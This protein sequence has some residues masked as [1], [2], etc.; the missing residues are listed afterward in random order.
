[1][2]LDFVFDTETVVASEKGSVRVFFF[3]PTSSEKFF[4]YPYILDCLSNLVHVLFPSGRNR[5]F[6]GRISLFG[7]TTCNTRKQVCDSQFSTICKQSRSVH[8]SVF[9]G[10]ELEIS[11]NF[12]HSKDDSECNTDTRLNRETAG[13]REVS[14]SQHK[15]VYIIPD[16]KNEG[17]GLELL[18]IFQLGLSLIPRPLESGSN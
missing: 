1:M 12:K 5:S 4:E 11:V 17:A 13:D 6:P 10:A 9:Q 15:K 8:T 3:Y 18:R 16:E 2:F 7:R 14:G